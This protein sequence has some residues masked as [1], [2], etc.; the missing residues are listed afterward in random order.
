MGFRQT[1]LPVSVLDSGYI[2]LTKGSF[3]ETQHKGTLANTTRPE[4]HH[5]IIVALLR[6]PDICRPDD[7]N[8]RQSGSLLRDPLNPYLPVAHGIQNAT[9]NPNA[10]PF[11]EK[12]AATL[13]DPAGDL[14]FA[15]L[16]TDV[17][18]S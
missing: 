2:R 18:T 10:S 8:P 11:F 17:Y 9:V 14:F 16:P 12:V 13:H 1:Y 4:H 7:V 6:H 3:H 15:P 5:A